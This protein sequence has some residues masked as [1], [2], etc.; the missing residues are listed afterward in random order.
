M[1]AEWTLKDDIMS[2]KQSLKIKQKQIQSGM[3]K[4]NLYKKKK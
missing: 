3:Q 4:T 1:K 2:I